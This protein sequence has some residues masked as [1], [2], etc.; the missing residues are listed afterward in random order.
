MVQMRVR[1]RRSR[2]RARRQSA[3]QFF[4]H[5]CG[6]AASAVAADLG[7]GAVGVVEAN[8]AGEGRRS[9]EELDAVGAD[10]G[11]AIAEALGQL[12]LVVACG[13]FFGDDEKVVAAGVC[14]RE[15]IKRSVFLRVA[16]C[17]QNLNGR[18]RKQARCAVFMLALGGGDAKS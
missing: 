8:A 16:E 18:L 12:G 9:I 17:F 10:A 2:W 11:V 13:G 15:G 5:P 7:D 6:D 1:R 14:F 4:G 3:I